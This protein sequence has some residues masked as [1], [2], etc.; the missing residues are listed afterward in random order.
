MGN[1]H[2]ERFNRTLGNMIRA[3]PP[4]DKLKWPQM[5]QTLTFAY[6]CTAH[7]STGYAPFYLMFGRVPRLPVDV[8]FHSVERDNDITDY[9]SYVRK[10]RDNLKEAL[11]LAQTNANASQQRQAELYNKRMKGSD[12]E[13]GD[14]V[15]L[16][17][18][19][20]RGR[21]K[22]ADRW[23]SVPY[24]VVSKDPQCHTYCV[25]SNRT[26]QEKVVHRNL[27]LQ[28]NFLPFDTDREVESS[29]SGSESDGS[30][31]DL[32]PRQSSMFEGEPDKDDQTASWIAALDGSAEGQ[33][34]SEKGESEQ[35]SVN[36]DLE[37]LAGHSNIAE[38][39]SLAVS[40][41]VE[42]SG[43]REDPVR[44]NTS[45]EHCSPSHVPGVVAQVRSR[46]GRIIRPVDRLIQNMTQKATHSSVKSFVK[47]LSS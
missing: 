38:N 17:N 20:E 13:E 12:I 14:Q 21:R 15:L 31:A 19:G 25:R 26:G 11:S 16:A 10:M 7:E 24:T 40:A 39:D 3:L 46:V 30:Q 27:M 5:L 45:T 2:V 34:T 32:S 44:P 33:C 9:D 41:D 28:V 18:K 37:S 8:V 23:E 6:N 29:F 42:V 1:G 4:R 22:L 47:A 35:Q 43:G 36:V